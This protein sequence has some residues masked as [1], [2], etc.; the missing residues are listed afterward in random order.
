VA[1]RTQVDCPIDFFDTRRW[2]A[3]SET[4][5][6]PG[7]GGLVQIAEFGRVH[8]SF[9]ELTTEAVGTTLSASCSLLHPLTISEKNETGRMAPCKRNVLTLLLI[10]A[11]G[12]VRVARARPRCNS[13][14]TICIDMSRLNWWRETLS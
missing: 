10:P 14:G 8:W 6:K 1:Q 12:E 5:C 9:G 4:V 13:V 2:P 11:A 7:T 3:V